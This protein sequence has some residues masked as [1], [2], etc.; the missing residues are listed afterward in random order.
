MGPRTQVMNKFKAGDRVQ[1]LDE[2][3]SGTVLEVFPDRVLL[4]TG[5]G[6][7]MEVAPQVLVHIPDEGLLSPRSGEVEEALREKESPRAKKTGQARKGVQGPVMEVD[8]HIEKLLPDTRGMSAY[9]ILDHQ[10][11]VARRQLEFALRKRVQRIVFIH[12]VGEGVLRAEL[13]T[14]IRRYEGLRAGDADYRAYGMGA[15][16]VYIPQNQMG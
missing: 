11:E 7:E 9:D 8:L 10:L 6:F 13:H 1:F 4:L 2:G 15:T 14:L 5:D 3:T 16:E 12:G